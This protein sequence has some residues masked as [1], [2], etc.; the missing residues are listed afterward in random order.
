M[1][2]I[3]VCRLNR[4]FNF[5]ALGVVRLQV[6]ALM[7]LQMVRGMDRSTVSDSCY[8]MDNEGSAIRAWLGHR[9]TAQVMCIQLVNT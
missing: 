9:V 4:W 8:V 5:A 7:F 3:D 2:P 1:Y 6:R